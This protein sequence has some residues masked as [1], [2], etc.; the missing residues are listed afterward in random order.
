MQHAGSALSTGSPIA[1]KLF[2]VSHSYFGSMK[3][4]YPLSRR[5]PFVSPKVPLPTC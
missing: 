1:I 2:A 4:L 5:K 3:L